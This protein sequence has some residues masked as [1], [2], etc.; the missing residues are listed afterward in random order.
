MVCPALFCCL[1][2][3]PYETTTGHEPW[4]EIEGKKVQFPF[5]YCL[6]APKCSSPP[7][8]SHS[9]VSNTS[10]GAFRHL[11]QLGAPAQEPD[12]WELAER[13]VSV[14]LA[15]ATYYHSCLSWH[16]LLPILMLFSKKMVKFFTNT[17]KKNQ[18]LHHLHCIPF[19]ICI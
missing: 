2:M 11:T 8:C 1:T 9:E 19:E 12:A 17:V 6:Q 14:D 10:C 13:H 4:F 7:V 18:Y 5:Q 15:T 16:R 3:Q